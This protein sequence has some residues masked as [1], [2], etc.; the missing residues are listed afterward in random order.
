MSMA[1]YDQQSQD[2]R[3]TNKF[4]EDGINLMLEVSKV[5]TLQGVPLIIMLNK[6]D[7][8]EEKIAVADVGISKTFPE[9]K[10]DKNDARQSIAFLEQLLS[11]IVESGTSSSCSIYVTQATDTN[12]IANVL[13]GTLQAIT[14]QNLREMGF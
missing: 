7:V 2:K 4:V 14:K 6:K 5:E 3:K 10:G 8:F 12:M 1:D 9:Y 11:D 13:A